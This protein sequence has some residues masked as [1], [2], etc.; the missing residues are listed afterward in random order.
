[1]HYGTDFTRER[2]HDRG[3]P[4]SQES[5]RGLAKRY[6]INAKTVAKWGRRQRPQGGNK[7]T[8]AQDLRTGPRDAHSTVLTIED[9]AVVQAAPYAFP[10]G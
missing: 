5:L 6:G 10:T 7:R 4:H 9:E 1:M 3:G 2:P 8:A